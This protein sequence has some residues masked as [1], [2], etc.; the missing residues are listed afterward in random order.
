MFSIRNM[1]EREKEK[2]RERE[3]MFSS[4]LNLLP[5]RSLFQCEL[6]IH[7]I[8]SS[9]FISLLTMLGPGSDLSSEEMLTGDS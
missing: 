5:S 1:H 7:H 9:G 4:L 6:Y 8:L 2:E 3:V